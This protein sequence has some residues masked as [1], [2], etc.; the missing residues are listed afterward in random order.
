MKK[1]YYAGSQR[2]AMRTG[3]TDP[4]W[5]FS[6]HLNSTSKIASATGT[7][8]LEQRYKAWGET[9][10]TSGTAPTTYKYTGQREESSFGLYYY[11]ARWYDPALGR[12]TQA[13]SIVPVA[14]QGVQAWDR[15]AYV[16]NNPINRNDPSGHCEGSPHYIEN[17]DIDCWN[18]WLAM[19]KDF[20]NVDVDN[21]FTLRE[22]KRINKSL[23][24]ARNTF[25]SQE[26][27][28]RAFGYFAID[29][30]NGDGS[31]AP[32][33]MNRIFL[34]RGMINGDKWSAVYNILHE[35]LHIFD[36]RSNDPTLY[37]SNLFLNVS[38]NP[39][40]SP[41]YVGVLGDP[42]ATNDLITKILYYLSTNWGSG[43]NEF[44]PNEVGPRDYSALSSIDYFADVGASYIM[45]DN[46]FSY[47]LEY[48]QNF[49]FATW[50][51]LTKR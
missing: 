2:I 23:T 6:D 32:A 8:T 47:N 15:Y 36:M 3:T 46:G 7:V 20:Y 5:I 21:G 50:V 30:I 13:D 27:F 48:Y 49:I 22:L 4:V 10:Y 28:F 44:Q 19:R 33:G 12:F 24:Y 38:K 29:P 11:G 39:S 16:S 14:S 40:A 25:E 35:I 9:R 18:Y 42:N 1:Y 17:P 51:N 45:N 26:G 31:I 41:G 37:K 34:G 43:W